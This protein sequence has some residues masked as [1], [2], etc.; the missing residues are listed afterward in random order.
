MTVL[1][2]ILTSWLISHVA[3][4]PHASIAISV[5]AA[6]S[7][8]LT[9]RQIP[10]IPKGQIV[11]QVVCLN[12]TNQSYALYLP[13]NYSPDRKWPVLYAFDPRAR[14]KAP[15]ERFKEAAEQYNWILVG[16]NNS[17]NGPL[18]LTVEAWNAIVKDTHERFAIDDERVYATGF[19]GA[20]RAAIYLAARCR[21][22]ISGVI[23]CGAG[24]PAGITPSPA[25]HFAVFGVAGVEDFNFPEV[26]DLDDALAKAGMTHRI[27][28]FD[29][30][31][32]WAPASMAMEAVEWLELKAMQAGKRTHDDRMIAAIRQKTL[33]R[34]R[35]LEEA[36]KTYDAYR[37]YAGA[38]DAVKGLLDVGDVE[39]KVNQ[40]RDRPEVKDAI[41]NE[42][43]QIKK[44]REI[45]ARL[46]I[47]IA[48]W[49]RTRTQD[50]TATQERSQATGNDRESTID[51]AIDS[52]TQLHATLDDLRKQ[53][54]GVEDSGDRR[55]ARRIL[56]GVFV[57]LYEQ[58]LDFL[59][60]RKLYGKAVRTFTLATEVY[61]DR[62]GALFY[63]AW[64][65]AADGQ[66]KKSL[67][68]LKTAVEKGLSDPAA[69]T[70]NKAFDGLRDDAQY[71]QIIQTLQNKH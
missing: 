56:E 4:A 12:N 22:C 40:L 25:L 7:N 71:R 57:S 37:A 11:E 55:I 3:T 67:Q 13:S 66:K 5:S 69:I 42:Q 53:S 65:Y 27:E 68:A 9:V 10:E 44:Q 62:A 60:A 15:L 63:L 35:A 50:S 54:K 59:Q 30:R 52:E 38:A 64:A 17:R 41:R 18:Q 29:G 14:G 32:E 36:K 43:R 51:E 6:H 21:D 20:A 34:A 1:A 49:E 24:F 47:L 28:V 19:S 46:N 8:S 31:H 39:K 70:G 33:E 61:P 45:E 26:K 16:S 23:V 2:L 58:G 48:R